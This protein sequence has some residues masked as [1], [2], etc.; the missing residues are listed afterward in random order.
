M[1][2]NRIRYFSSSY[3]NSQFRSTLNSDQPWQPATTA[4]TRQPE[5]ACSTTAACSID[6]ALNRQE[7]ALVKT[8]LVADLLGPKDHLLLAHPCF[9][10]NQAVFCRLLATSK[11]LLAAC[12]TQLCRTASAMACWRWKLGMPLL[13][14]TTVSKVQTSSSQTSRTAGL[15]AAEACQAA[16]GSHQAA[17]GGLA[18]LDR[19]QCCCHGRWDEQTLLG[20][21]MLYHQD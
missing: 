7:S 5:H 15:L 19:S 12:S 6:P 9:S 21:R 11:T 13:E 8:G 3:A 18:T 2:P 10:D 14:E 17:P 20:E 1:A 16:Q 4:T